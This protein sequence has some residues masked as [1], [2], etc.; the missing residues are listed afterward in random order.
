M[1]DEQPKQPGP[2]FFV[3]RKLYVFA[4]VV[5]AMW[6]FVAFFFRNPYQQAVSFDYYDKHPYDET[7]VWTYVLVVVPLIGFAAFLIWINRRDARK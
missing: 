1:T 2:P 3:S 6:I 5:I 4:A 7:M